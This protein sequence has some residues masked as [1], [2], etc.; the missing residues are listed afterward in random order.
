M[1]F[2]INSGNKGTLIYQLDCER[3]REKRNHKMN[4]HTLRK[5]FLERGLM[6]SYFCCLRKTP[7][8]ILKCFVLELTVH[9]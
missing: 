3:T 5:M 6:P 2:N 8:A 7:K 9:E 1:L 4:F